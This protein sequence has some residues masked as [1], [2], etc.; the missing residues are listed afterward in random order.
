[1]QRRKPVRIE[2]VLMIFSVIIFGVFLVLILTYYGRVLKAA[3]YKEEELNHVY[4]YQYEM[5]VDN[6]NSTLWNEVYEKAKAEAAENDALLSLRVSDANTEYDKTDYVDMCIDS[7]ADGII[8]EYNGEPGLTEKINEAAE[9]GIPVVTIMN[10]P[11]WSSRQS[12]VGVNEYQMGQA[13]GEQVARLINEDTKDI[14]ILSNREPELEKNQLYSRIYNAVSDRTG[15]EKNIHVREQNLISK[16]QFDVEEAV[17]NIFQSSDGPPEMI[18]C[19]DEVTTVCAYQA[20]IDFNMVGE[21][22]IIGYDASETILEAVE[23]GLIPV[24]FA[25][26]AGQIAEYS[27]EALTEYRE[28][29]RSNAYYTVDLN[30]ITSQDSMNDMTS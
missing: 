14:L 12:Y 26:D 29:G 27:I 16:S 23:K 3:G 1:M 28:I 21:V 2:I 4:G 13:Y 19:L 18:I 5:I 6:R 17:R 7:K 10:D 11:S 8:L 30:V 22:S 20:M 25:M 24:T 9:Q 15:G